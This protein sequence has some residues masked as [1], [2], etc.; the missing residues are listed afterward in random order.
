MGILSCK[1]IRSNR[2]RG[3]PLLFENDLKSKGRSA[4]DFRT[5]AKKG[6]IA[7]A[8]YDNRR[9]TAT[10]TYLGIKPK[11]T[12]ERWD[13]RE[14]KVMDLKSQTLQKITT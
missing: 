8:W 2:L 9:V 5:D 6:I 7:V 13:G 11:L 1:T 4:Y 10:S 3:C 14:Q 12:V